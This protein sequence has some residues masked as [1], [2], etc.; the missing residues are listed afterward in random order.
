M[1]V[2]QFTATTAAGTLAVLPVAMRPQF[3]ICGWYRAANTVMPLTV[4]A[5]GNLE[6][7][8]AVTSG[9]NIIMFRYGIGVTLTL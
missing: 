5:N 4:R 2:C 1:I 7:N 3:D 6:I 8:G 9:T